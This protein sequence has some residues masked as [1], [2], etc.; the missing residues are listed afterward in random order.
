MS[1][2]KV[3]YDFKTILS[4]DLVLHNLSI[5]FAVKRFPNPADPIVS[6]IFITGDNDKWLIKVSRT[7]YP[8]ILYAINLVEN[9]TR[10]VLTTSLLPARS[11]LL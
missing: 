1:E 3:D 11:T 4:E 2:T 10:I 9:T 6:P 7:R 5:L 8:Y